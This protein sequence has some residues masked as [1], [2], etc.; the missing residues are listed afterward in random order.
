MAGER[1]PDAQPVR[2]VAHAVTEQ[3]E[4]AEAGA[5][6]VGV[7]LGQPQG[8]ARPEVAGAEVLEAGAL[9]GGG[10][11]G[12]HVQLYRVPFPV[13]ESEALDVG[14]HRIPQVGDAGSGGGGH[15]CTENP[16][17]T[18]IVCPVM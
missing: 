5:F 16:P 14:E 10:E 2:R 4:A 13:V 1:L 15:P 11:D 12:L 7:H 18:G 6:G 3:H 17:S 9:D 8:E